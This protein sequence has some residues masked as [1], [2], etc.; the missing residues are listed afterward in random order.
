MGTSVS[1]QHFTELKGTREALTMELKS[2]LLKSVLVFLVFCAGISVE[3]G[4]HKEVKKWKKK[5]ENHHFMT[6]CWGA[7]TMM[8]F[9]K[10]AEKFGMECMQLTP[11]FDIDLFA[12]P[13]NE[14]YNVVGDE[15][16]NPFF[17][18]PAGTQTLPAQVASPFSPFRG[19]AP[20]L[21][22]FPQ[23]G[24]PL[25]SWLAM[26]A[27]LYQ[28]YQQQQARS[29]QYYPNMNVQSRSK[30]AIDP[31]TKEELMEF[32]GQVAEFKEHKKHK[33]A[34]LTCVLR[35]FNSLNSNLGINLDHFTKDMW[36]QFAR[37]ED[38]DME[39]QE[40]M[41][42]GYQHCY[43]MASNIPADLLAKKGPFYEQFGRQMMFFKCSKM[44][45]DANCVMKELSVWTEYLWGTPTEEE[46]VQ[47]RLPRDLYK[48][49][50]MAWTVEMGKETEVQKFVHDFLF[51][52]RK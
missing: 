10:A 41:Q 1:F 27:P 44:M 14:E 21:P 35:K 25:E 45:T 50:L 37:G 38:P 16:E 13:E 4:A 7:G 32:A 48:A 39:F 23:Q 28:Q 22:Q 43:Q 52:N 3:A 18:T 40:H 36:T 2:Q 8:A 17:Q 15:M 31:P 47:L 51:G 33:M 49:N 20:Q 30:R 29:F 19:G 34:N 46:R 5:I 42:K 24:N 11:A 9:Y 12:E 6:K 26:W